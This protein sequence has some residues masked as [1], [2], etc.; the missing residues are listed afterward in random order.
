MRI[1]VSPMQSASKIFYKILNFKY[2]KEK[3]KNLTTQDWK[4]LKSSL[5]YEH[6]KGTLKWRYKC[7]IYI[8]TVILWSEASSMCLLSFVLN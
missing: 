3:K 5:A 4:S 2:L 6:P 1:A 7:R 8:Y